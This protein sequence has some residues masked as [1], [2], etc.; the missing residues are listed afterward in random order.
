MKCTVLLLTLYSL[1]SLSA[2]EG[3]PIGHIITW[4]GQ[5]K[6]NGFRVEKGMVVF[7]GS[8][9]VL[10]GKFDPKSSITI[11]SYSSYEKVT[12]SCEAHPCNEGIELREVQRSDPAPPSLASFFHALSETIGSAHTLSGYTRALSKGPHADLADAIAKLTASGADLSEALQKLPAGTYHIEFC[13]VTADG[14][15][16]CSPSV[17]SRELKWSPA[18]PESAAAAG[19]AAG[20]YE[21]GVYE[22]VAGD[23]APD[24]DFAFV[25]VVPQEKA[26]AATSQYAEAVRWTE[27]WDKG[28]AAMA[29]HAYLQYLNKSLNH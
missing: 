15:S 9:L 1:N 14:E 6:N 25:L 27:A 11:R 12:Y 20:L 2:A 19:I 24:R 17:E 13:P 22:G 7:D 18:Q 16:Q 3:P 28:E 21:I 5:W 23:T 26:S 4:T 10:S 29:R 8:K